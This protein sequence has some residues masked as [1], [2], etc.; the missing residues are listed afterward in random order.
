MSEVFP[1][2]RQSVDA[3]Y[4]AFESYRVE[5]FA[6][7]S[8]FDYG[9]SPSELRGI[10]TVPLEEI[11]PKVVGKMEFFA[12]DWNS[13][14]TESEVKHFL[15]RILECL[16]EAPNLL[17]RPGTMSLFKQKLAKG[18]TTQSTS[19]LS[20]E[21]GPVEDFLGR[22][23]VHHAAREK[24]GVRTPLGYLL[25]ALVEIGFGARLALRVFNELPQSQRGVLAERIAAH[26]GVTRTQT[27]PTGA[28]SQRVH[29]LRVYSNWALENLA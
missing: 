21:R 20:Y 25:E 4:Q 13:W 18:L 14:G 19:L 23:L 8:V 5:D 26:F 2:L 16:I 9:P 6:E 17:E 29:G 28:S 12:S 10:S 7:V 24:A 15:P 3:L 11:S 27:D 1:E 22:L